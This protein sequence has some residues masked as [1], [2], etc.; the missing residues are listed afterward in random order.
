MR[1]SDK[2]AAGWLSLLLL[3]PLGLG[4]LVLRDPEMDLAPRAGN[5]P[6][7]TPSQSPE[8]ARPKARV[9]R[10]PAKWASEAQKARVPGAHRRSTTASAAPGDENEDEILLFEANQNRL[11]LALATLDRET[12]GALR[13]EAESQRLREELADWGASSALELSTDIE[14]TASV[15]SILWTSAAPIEQLVLELTPWIQTQGQYAVDED[16]HGK[17]QSPGDATASKLRL[18]FW[19]DGLPQRDRRRALRSSS[20]LRSGG[21]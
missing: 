2:A 15:C 8:R 16:A 14:C 18:F 5:A 9:E 19:R 11:E 12:K 7:L 1:L 4:L 17:E 20:L 3:L 10:A 21:G 13:D 6:D